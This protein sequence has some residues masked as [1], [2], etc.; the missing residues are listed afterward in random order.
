LGA[1]GGKSYVGLRVSRV[2]HDCKPN[3]GYVY[4][5][6]RKLV[7]EGRKINAKIDEFAGKGCFEEAL[8]FGGKMLD[9]QRRLQSS[10]LCRA[11]TEFYLFQVTLRKRKTMT[12]AGPHI[13]AVMNLYKTI[14]PY[15]EKTRKYESSGDGWL[16]FD[17]GEISPYLV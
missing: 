5:E 3:T 13:K 12:K 17:Y 15:S 14:C 6:I 4:D 2:N 1:F 16:L 7:L 8:E 9:I 10:C 11:G